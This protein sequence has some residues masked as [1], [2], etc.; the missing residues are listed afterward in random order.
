MQVQSTQEQPALV[1]RTSIYVEKLSEVM[2][3]SYG[4]IIQVSGTS[5]IQSAALHSPSITTWT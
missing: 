4:E 1:V 2:G 5:S 3:S